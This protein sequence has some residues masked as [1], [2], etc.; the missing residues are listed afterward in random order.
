MLGE[1]AARG[2]ARL[3]LLRASG[4]TVAALYGFSIGSTFQFYQCG[5]HPA[6]L[7]LGVG[8][9]IVGG[10]IH[11]AIRAGHAEFDFLRGDESYKAQWAELSR[12]TVTVRLFDRRPASL[13]AR[14]AYGAAALLRKAKRRLGAARRAGQGERLMTARLQTLLATAGVMLVSAL[15]RA[16]LWTNDLQRSDSADYLRAV[17]DGAHGRTYLDTN[18]VSFARFVSLMRDRALTAGHPWEYLSRRSDATALRHFHVPLGFYASAVAASYRASDRIHRILPVF[19][20]VALCGLV[21]LLMR[22]LGAGILLSVVT[23][24][25]LRERPV[26]RD[27]GRSVAPSLVQNGCFVFLERYAAWLETGGRKLLLT[28][29]ALAVAFASME[30]APALVLA[31]VPAT[32]IAHPEWLRLALQPRRWW[33][34]AVAAGVVFLGILVVAWPGGILR[35]GYLVSYATFV[36]QALFKRGE[37]FLPLTWGGMYQRLFDSIAHPGSAVRRGLDPVR[38]PVGAPAGAGERVRFRSLC[39]GGVRPECGQ[40]LHEQHLRRGGDCLPAARGGIAIH[41]GSESFAPRARTA[42]AVTGC[43]LIGFCAVEEFRSGPVHTSPA[44]ALELAVKSLPSLVPGGTTVLVNRNPQTF[45]AY[46]PGY[47]IEATAAE[48]SA[49]PGSP[50]LAGTPDYLVLDLGPWPLKPCAPSGKLSRGGPICVEEG[51]RRHRC[52]A[53][54]EGLRRI[55]MHFGLDSYVAYILYAA[56]VAAMLASLFWRPIAGIFYLL[57]LLPLQTIRYRMN[58]LPM[59]SSVIGIMLLAVLLGVLRRGHPVLPKTPWTRLLVIYGVF[60]YAS[61][62]LGALYLGS[63]FPLFGDPRFAYWQEYMAMPAL[64]L[65]VPAVQ[66]TR[67]QMI[68]VLVMCLSGLMLDRNFSNEVSGRD[69]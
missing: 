45:A 31:A 5:M 40:R 17:R 59:G 15:V 14:I 27:D 33:R 44:D 42:A 1:A 64:L 23:A 54:A 20:G 50:R 63:G 6:W 60:T 25:D 2:W 66:P 22:R 38:R 37:M 46:L 34:D 30:L 52:L 49:Q 67:R 62:C 35:G 47:R 58:D 4:Q 36:A 9:L 21:V 65:L 7:N 8:Q 57:P 19:A 11:E 56:G 29:V 10:S 24:R 3:F 16:P 28:S 39:G 68:P 48:S 13:A 55:R 43:L 41:H 26:R 53:P 69:F 32:F 18:S 61:L 12:W 51:R